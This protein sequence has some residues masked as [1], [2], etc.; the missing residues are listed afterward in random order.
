MRSKTTSVLVTCGMSDA[1]LQSKLAG[2]ISSSSVGKIILIR[3]TPICADKIDNRNPSRWIANS[4]V[5]FE[6]WRFFTVIC[7]G[8]RREAPV[9]VGIQAQMHGV[10]A[11]LAAATVGAKSILW[12]IGSD[13][14]IYSQKGLFAPLVRM[15]MR[16]ADIVFVM[17]DRSRQVV[18]EVCGRKHKVFVQQN[19]F[20]RNQRNYSGRPAKKW[21]LIFVGNF[22]DVKDPLAAISVFSRVKDERPSARFCMLGDG[23]LRRVVWEKIESCG[24]ESCVDSPGRVLDPLIYMNQSRVLILTSQNEGLPAVLLEASSQGVPV[25]STSVGEI[26]QIAEE[27]EGIHGVPTG[28]IDTFVCKCLNLLSDESVYGKSVQSVSEFSSNHY[29]KWS[30]GGQ[31]KIWE[32]ALENM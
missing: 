1:K 2:L 10:V 29:R 25:V 19:V 18:R 4:I 30:L 7:I 23:E 28:D 20:E 3:K 16:R 26:A 15:S 9:L 21:D 31:Q 8:L 6:L 12:L 27:Y 11:V 22:V 17:G 13:L 32:R 24:L 5:F 14:S